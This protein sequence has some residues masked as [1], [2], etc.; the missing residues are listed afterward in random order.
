MVDLIPIAD[1]PESRYKHQNPMV[2]QI[3]DAL[4]DLPPNMAL[5]HRASSIEEVRN[6]GT[7]LRYYTH[8]PAYANLRICQ[9][10]LAVFCWLNQEKL[11]PP[12]EDAT[13]SSTT[14]I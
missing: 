14:K 12:T 8:K 13:R 1:I 7:L 10:E 4:S 6:L 9:R 5:R 3:L 11:P 2:K